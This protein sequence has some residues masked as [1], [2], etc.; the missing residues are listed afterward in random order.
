MA[1]RFVTDKTVKSGLK[2]K[3]NPL[4]MYA[5]QAT[6]AKCGVISSGYGGGVWC[7]VIWYNDKG[8]PINSN[9]YRVKGDELDLF[10]YEDQLEFEF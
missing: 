7:F 9:S 5:K 1:D 4:S 6:G 3:I 10:H 2:V 8:D